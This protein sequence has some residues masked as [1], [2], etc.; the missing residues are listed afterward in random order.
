MAD[1]G[2]QNAAVEIILESRQIKLKVLFDVEISKLLLPAKVFFVS[3]S[4]PRTPI[5]KK[6][7]SSKNV[8]SPLLNMTIQDRWSFLLWRPFHI[9]APTETNRKE[10]SHTI[11]F[12]MISML[13][14]VYFDQHG[15]YLNVFDVA[16]MSTAAF[17]VLL[18][19][20]ILIAAWKCK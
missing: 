3:L 7:N 10:V 13:L 11:E 19:I 16:L 14:W 18:A 12:C 8:N 1:T 6:K 5:L 9:Y 2:V 17:F 4:R 15:P 20:V